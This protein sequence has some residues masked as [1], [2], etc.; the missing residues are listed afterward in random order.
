[1]Q[2]KH[3]LPLVL[4]IP[5]FL[6]ACTTAP[7]TGAGKSAKA[8]TTPVVDDLFG[9][10]QAAPDANIASYATKIKRSIEEKIYRPDSYKG[11]KCTLRILLARD[12]L[13]MSAT[14]ENGNPELCHA[15]LTAVK[16]ANM[17]P[18]PDEKTWQAFR[19][20]SLDFSY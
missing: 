9:D 2:P 16:Q 11:Q 3:V 17:P 7:H 15:A 19:N 18:A 12:G 1:M 14:A 5:L 13:V 8:E 4:F 6:A 20:A 10:L